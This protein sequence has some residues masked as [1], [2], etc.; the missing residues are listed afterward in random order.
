MEEF[1]KET[2]W[3]CSGFLFIRKFQLMDVFFE[4]TDWLCSGFFFY[5]EISAD[6]CVLQGDRLA[7][8]WI[9]FYQGFSADGRVLR[10]DGLALLPWKL[11]CSPG[12]IAWGGDKHTDR[13]TSRLLE[14]MG[15]RANSLKIE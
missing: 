12:R 4:E 3:L 9:L 7:L 10:G 11:L 14:R 8:L 2:D 13:Q 15:L 5:Q 1:F 6:G